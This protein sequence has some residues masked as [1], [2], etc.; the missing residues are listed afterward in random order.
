ML[1]NS[2]SS[3]WI[4]FYKWKGNFYRKTVT[5]KDEAEAEEIAVKTLID[6]GKGTDCILVAIVPELSDLTFI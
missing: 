1:G 6:E 4:V 5:A 3:R 2:N